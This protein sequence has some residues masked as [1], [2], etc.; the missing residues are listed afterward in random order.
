MAKID[1][2]EYGGAPEFGYE[3]LSVIPY[4]YHLHKKGLLEETF[5][6]KDT[7]VFYWFSNKHTEV[8]DLKRGW[9][10]TKNYRE[11]K[12]PNINIHRTQLDWKQ[13]E[14]PIFKR[15]YEGARMTFEKETIVIINRYNVEWGEKPINFFDLK[16]LDRL[17]RALQNDYQIVYCNLGGVPELKSYDDN[18]PAMDLG[19]YK[20][21]KRYPKV[22]H[23]W[24]L[25]QKHKEK[26]KTINNLQMRVFAGCSKYI[27]MNG[28]YGIWASMMGGENIIYSKRCNELKSS[29]NSFNS[30]YFK[31]EPEYKTM[32]NH[33]SSYSELMTLVEQKWVK[34]LPPI[35][36]LVRTHHRKDL[37]KRAI[38]T[39]HN[40]TY[41]NVRILVACDTK[42]S[43]LY[44]SKEKVN[45]VM[46]R[47]HASHMKIALNPLFGKPFG[48]N[49]Y[50]NNLAK[51]VGLGLVCYLDDDDYYLYNDALMKIAKA[52]T[53]TLCT[54]TWRVLA[55]DGVRVIP[56][57]YNFYEAKWPAVNDFSGLGFAYDIS[58]WVPWEAYRRGDFRVGLSVIRYTRFSYGKIIRID[59]VLVAAG[60]ATKN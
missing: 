13:W 53:N 10:F 58:R 55:K 30:W 51:Y 39:I 20:F 31:L 50:F 19:D 9:Q 11:K 48:P 1:L 54:I 29:V 21:L 47:T 45:P 43:F 37:F 12:F 49:V 40:Q 35:T 18:A 16:T 59:E 4:A 34:K 3:L 26:V 23:I 57:D 8:E 52:Y 56:D 38:T 22:I 25:F 60:D 7:S 15:V 2:R 5:S 33:V 42:E 46:V 32:V 27:T 44:A 41:K 17:F 36:I 24:D 14:N 28:G 6:T